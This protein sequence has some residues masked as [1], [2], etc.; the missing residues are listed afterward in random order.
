M[1]CMKI[2]LTSLNGCMLV[3]RFKLFEGLFKDY[4]TSE[5]HL[6]TKVK[7]LKDVIKKIKLIDLGSER[8]FL[9]ALELSKISAT[10]IEINKSLVKLSNKVK[11]NKLIFKNINGL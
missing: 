6:F 1:E 8:Q 5:K 4:D 7:F 9:R 2:C 11:R 3:M 10:G